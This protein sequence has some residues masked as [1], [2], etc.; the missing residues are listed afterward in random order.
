M[1]TSERRMARRAAQD[2]PSRTDV[3]AH[4]SDAVVG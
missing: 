4:T 3:S 1:L 2:R